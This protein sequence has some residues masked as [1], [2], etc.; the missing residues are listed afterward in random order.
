MN[1]KFNEQTLNKAASI[2]EITPDFLKK[3]IIKYNKFYVTN[4]KSFINKDLIKINYNKFKIQVFVK[5]GEIEIMLAQKNIN[6]ESNE[7]IFK[8]IIMNSLLRNKLLIT[9]F[10]IFY[11]KHTL[12]E[13]NNFNLYLKININEKKETIKIFKEEVFVLFDY[14]FFNTKLNNDYFDYS[15]FDF[16]IF[17]SNSEGNY[18]SEVINEFKIK[19]DINT[20]SIQSLIQ[21]YDIINY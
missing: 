11:Q 6:S 12:K 9:D 13:K 15:N 21:F 10:F 8:K 14:N 1:I 19:Y 5:T 18:N 17:E 2:L 4:P 16:L 3:L 7:F 20:C